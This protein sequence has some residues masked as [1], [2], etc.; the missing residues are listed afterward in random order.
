MLVCFQQT[1]APDSP[2]M[3]RPYCC[4]L[5]RMRQKLEENFLRLLV[6][7]VANAGLGGGHFLTLETALSGVLDPFQTRTRHGQCD[8]SHRKGLFSHFRMLMKDDS[9]GHVLLDCC[10][11]LRV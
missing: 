8:A 6:P 5:L 2:A 9:A 7:L 1:S 4:P 3:V 10:A 11:L